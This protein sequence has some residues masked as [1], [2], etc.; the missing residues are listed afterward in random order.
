MSPILPNQY[1]MPRRFVLAKC[2][3]VKA[4]VWVSM[5]ASLAEPQAPPLLEAPAITAATNA[6][7]KIQFAELVFDFGK[8]ESGSLVKH[9]FIFTNIGDQTLEV[10]NVRPSCGCTT[11]GTWDK[12]VGPGKTGTI[13]IQFNSAGSAGP[14]AKSIEVSCNDPARSTVTLQL[15]GTTWKAIDVTPPVVTFALSMDAQTNE[16]RVIR[17]VNNLQEPLAISDPACTNSAFQVAL[18]SI[19]DG[20][21]FQLEVTLMPPLT[22]NLSTQITLKTSYPKMPVLTVNAYA[23][24]QPAITLSPA[25]I[26][27]PSGPLESLTKPMI[28]I[29]NNSATPLALSDP[30]ITA[31]DASVQLK[32]LQTG[33]A[34]ALTLSLPAG[35]QIQPGDTVE[36]TVKSSHPKFPIIKVPVKQMPP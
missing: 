5:L 21:E 28:T 29:R 3:L 17:I 6:G 1:Q 11:A 32:E 23:T 33:R 35:F 20:K 4:F 9:D 31:H 8:V 10:T 34:F 25:Q 12:S 22:N 13:P 14:V 7:P 30:S 24:V 26:V 18:K 19:K 16:T 2:M 15:R 36:A 27:L